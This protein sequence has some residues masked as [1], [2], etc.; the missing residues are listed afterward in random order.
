MGRASIQA[1]G[2]LPPVERKRHWT[3]VSQI[4]SVGKT[5]SRKENAPSY[6]QAIH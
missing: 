1:E 4:L 3:E 6:H 2:K 5:K